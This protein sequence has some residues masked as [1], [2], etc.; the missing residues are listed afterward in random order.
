MALIDN[1]VGAWK[2]D[3]DAA[4]T[5]IIDSTGTNNATLVGGDNTEDKSVAG[6]L[7]PAIDMN[8]TDDYIRTDSNVQALND[9]TVAMWV[10][11]D[12]FTNEKYMY[13][14][15]FNS[16]DSFLFYNRNTPEL[17]YFVDG[18]GHN[19]GETA[20]SISND[21]LIVFTRNG[22]T[23][24]TYV[25]NVEVD[26]ATVSSQQIVSSRH[27][28]GWAFVRNKAGTYYNGRMQHVYLWSADIGSAGVSELWNSGTGSAYPFS[29]EVN[30]STLTATATL[31]VPLIQVQ[32][33][34]DVLSAITTLPSVSVFN[35]TN[36]NMG[37]IG[38]KEITTIY[39]ITEGLIARTTKQTGNPNLVATEEDGF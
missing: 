20:P 8:G 26:S 22:T 36:P 13:S 24:K 30:V 14:M 16:D 38:T 37:K 23:L 2:L 29:L 4:S 5:V 17:A 34:P 1:I 32:I 15:S 11:S 18:V 39:P 10:N 25:D 12:D 28:F 31:Q 33:T 19:T 3:D 9:F 21:H 35:P 7:G 27:E 6:H